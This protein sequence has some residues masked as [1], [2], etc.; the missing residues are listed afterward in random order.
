M[1]YPVRTE[2]GAGKQLSL[3]LLKWP[4]LTKTRC[5]LHSC[6]KSPKSKII[7]NNYYYLQEPGIPKLSVLSFTGG[8]H[9]RSIGKF[10]M[11]FSKF[12]DNFL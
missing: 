6:D 12:K 8:F 7:T 3:N 5:V 2:K 9:G 4:V 1:S 10:C 11:Q